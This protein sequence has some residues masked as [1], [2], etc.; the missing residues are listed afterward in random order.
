MLMRK[1]VSFAIGTPIH[2]FPDKYGI[3]MQRLGG[4]EAP[5]TDHE[6]QAKSPLG[7]VPLPQSNERSHVYQRG[8]TRITVAHIDVIKDAFWKEH[9]WIIG[10][11]G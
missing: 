5:S 2:R 9:P 11:E 6:P 7:Q 10:E 8:K 4:D 1:K 3:D